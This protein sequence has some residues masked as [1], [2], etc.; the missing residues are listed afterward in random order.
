MCELQLAHRARECKFSRR[1]RS[2]LRR[3]FS[4][5]RNDLSA[6][7]NAFDRFDT[8]E[9]VNPSSRLPSIDGKSAHEMC[10]YR[11]GRHERGEPAWKL[12]QAPQA[13]R[14]LTTR[15]GRRIDAR[16]APICRKGGQKCR[17]GRLS[18]WRRRSRNFKRR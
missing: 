16:R 4:V 18:S 8:I 5:R 17:R 7:Y 15:T 9:L 3:R 6:V 13:R 12:E 14:L 2:G 11:E 10:R 1:S